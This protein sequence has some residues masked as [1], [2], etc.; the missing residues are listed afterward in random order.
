MLNDEREFPLTPGQ[1]DIWLAQEI[2][3]SAAEWIL[4]NLVAIDGAAELEVL[5]R[6]I[7]LVVAEAEPLRTVFYEAGG[8]VVQRAADYPDFDVCVHDLRGAS[9]PAAEVRRLAA[10]MGRTPMPLDGP[11]FKFALAS[12]ANDETYIVNC[13]HHIAV[14]GFGAMLISNRLGAVYSALLDDR[15][16]P[17]TYFGTIRDLVEYESDY[18][19]SAD[20]LQDQAYWA[21]HK[22]SE[23]RWDDWQPGAVAGRGE[24]V[25][26]DP[27]QLDPVLVARIRELCKALNVRRSAI[28]AAAFAVL[29]GK[30]SANHS[31]VAVDFSVSRRIGA[32]SM[33]LPAMMTGTVPLTINASPRWNIADLCGDVHAG[34]EC[35]VQH[36]RFPRRLIDGGGNSGDS[37]G[38]A[39]KLMINFIPS[40]TTHPY[41]KAAA[42]ATCVAFGGVTGFGVYFQN[43]GQRLL[44]STQGLAPPFPEFATTHTLAARLE[45]ILTAMVADPGLRLSSLDMLD[46]G[47]RAHLDQIGN[48]AALIR[49]LSGALLSIPQAFAGQVARIPDNVALVC[50]GASWT[51]REVDE[52]AHGLAHF[53]I[54]HGAGPGGCV[55]LVF[56]RCAEA[57]IA[58]LGV[59]KTGAAYV[60]ID[61]GLPSARVGFM[62]ADTSPVA[63]LTTTALAGRLHGLDVP[64]IEITD[65]RIAT[66]PEQ[67]L[68][69]PDAENLAYVIYTSGT[70]GVPKGVAITHCNVTALMASLDADL[71]APGQ[72]WSQ[73]H[74]YSFDISGWEIFGALLHGGRLVIVPEVVARSP[75]Q[76]HELLVAEQVSVLSQTPSAVGMLSSEGLESTA[77][78]VGGEACPGELVDRWAPGRVMINEYGPT[79]TTMWVALS[80]PLSAES[81]SPPIGMPV[82]GAALFVLDEWL[83]AVPVGAVGELYVAGTGVGVGYWRRPGLTGSR[84]VACPFAVGARMY[85]TGDLVR[86]RADGQLEYLGRSDEQVKVRGYRIELGEI[87]AALAEL[88]GVEQAVVIAR[89][90]RPGDKCLVGYVTGTAEVAKLRAAL[91][92]RLPGY[93]VPS[94]VV[95]ID[96]LPLTVSG[97]LDKRA[98]PAPDYSDT[99]SYRAPTNAVEE[100]LAG[101]FAHVLGVER[102]G[103]DDSFFDL[104]G[105]SLLAMRLTAAVSSGLN[106]DLSVRVVFDAP[107]V[108]QLAPRLGQG[109]GRLEPLVVGERPEVVP[110]S[111]AQSRLWFIDQLQGPSSTDNMAMALRLHGRLGA[112]LLGA[113]LADVVA[114]HE[115][116]RTLFV[117]HGG[118]PR[119]VVI[120]ANEADFGLDEVDATGWPVNRLDEAI[121][122]AARHLFDLTTQIP[123]YARIFRV[124][125]DEHVLVAVAHHIA[126]DG[127]SIAPLIRDLSG[128]Y[129]SRCAGQA[130]GWADLPVQYVDY[131]LWQRAQFGDLSD[132]ES[133]IAAQ[134]AYWEEALA[135]MPEH[136]Q[137]PTDRPYPPVAD[138]RGASVSVEWSTELQQRID[139]VAREHNATSFMVMQ[140]GLAVLLSNLS[141]S[142][143]VAMGFPIGGR[144]DPVLDDLVGFFVN[145]L[146]LRVDLAGDP[147]VAELL[148]QVRAR[149]LAA[150]EYQDVPFEVLVE[151]LNP[152]RS[153]NRHPLI[154]VMLSWRKVQ[155]TG[156]S[157][158]LALGDL[159]VTQMPLDTRT[160]RVD[161][162]FALAERRTRFGEPAGI[163]G[164][165]EFRKDVFDAATIE[166][167]TGRLE[168]LLVAITAEPTQRLSSI[169]LLDAAEHARLDEWGHRAVLRTSAPEPVS[170]PALFF[171]QVTRMPEAVALSF[172]G[173][174]MTYRELDEVSNRLAHL[175]VSHGV[176]PGDVVGLLCER[177]AQAVIAILAV[178][179]ARAAY[180]PI[181]PVLP[182]ARIEFILEDA[183]PTA[184]VSSPELLGRLASHNLTVININGSTIATSYPTHPLP[185]PAADD[186]AY[187]IYTSGTT[188][189]PK[190]VAITHHNV[191]QLM[192]SLDDRLPLAGAWSQWHSYGF[193]VSVQEIF[194]ALLHG[195]RLVIVPE[196]MTRAPEDFHALLVAEQ[197]TVLSQTPS[198]L[199]MLS[200]RGLDS[201]ALLIMG[202][203]PCPAELVDRWAP[204]RAMINVCGPTEVSMFAAMSAPLTPASAG[205]PIGSPVPGAALFVLDRWLRPVPPGV[206][207]ELYVAGRVGV[208]YWRR[209]GLTGSRFVACPFGGFGARMYRTGD[210]VCWRPDGQLD[211]RGRVDQQVK[212]RGYRIEC[213]EVAAALAGVDGVDQAVVIARED[214]PG[215]KRL[216]G[217]ITGT[218]DPV[219]VRASL[220]Q[221]LPGYMV[222]AAVVVLDTVPLTVNGKLDT[223]ALPVPGYAGISGYRAP[224]T[225]TEEILAGTYAQILGVT[226]VGI[227][228]SFF[229]LGGDSLSAMRVIAAINTTLNTDLAVRALFE[230]PMVAQ[231]ASRVGATRSGGRAPLVVAERPAVVALSFAQSRLWFID[232]L[233]GPSPVYNIAVG[234]HLGG[235]LDAGALSVALTD[236]VGRHESLRTIFG[237]AEGV[238]HQVVVAAERA[239]VSWSSVDA[240]GWSHSRLQ[241]AIQTAACYSFD[242]AVEI[243]V[244]ATLYTVADEQHV[245]VLV[246]HHIA[247]DGWSLAPLAADLGVAYASRCAGRVPDWAPLPVQYIDYTLWQRAD[248]GDVSDPDSALAVQVA[249]WEQ[250]LAG[251][252]EWLQLPTDRP[253]PPVADHRGA[254]VEVDWSAGLQQQ[255]AGIAREHTA[256]SF[257]V[258]HAGLA[259]LLSGL[260]G[261]TDV[262]VGVPIAGRG[263]PALDALVGFFVNTLVLRVDLSANPTFVELL[264]QTRTRSLAAYDHQDVPFEVLVE[265]LDPT[266]SQ[267]HHPVFQVMLA[268]QNNTVPVLALGDLQVTALP[269]DTQTARMDLVFSLSEC[270]SDSGEPAGISGVVEFRTDVFDTASIHIMVQRLEQILVAMTSEPTQ[271]V[272]CLDLLTS[273]EHALLD[274]VGNRAVLSAP[275]AGVAASVPALFAAVVAR[276][277]DEVAVT[278]QGLSLTYRQL[279]EASTGLALVLAGQGAGPGQVVALLLSRSVEAI[280]A[281]LAVLKAGA[282]YLP[283]DPHHPDARI[284]FMLSD[285]APVVGGST[286]ALADRLASYDLPV[287]DLNDPTILVDRDGGLSDP[288]PYGLAYLIYTSGTTGVPKGVAIT[289]HNVTQLMRSL[290]DR[291]PL[292]GAWSQWHSYGFDFSVFEIFGALLHGGRLVVVP[293]SVAGSP[294]DFHALLVAEHVSVLTSTPSALSMLSSQGLESVALLVGGEACPVE[295]VDRWAPGRVMFNAYGPTES[296]MYASISTPLVAGLG[297]APIGSPVVGA[298]L[299][300]LDEWLRAVPPGVVGEL[301][302]AGG[303]VGVG[304]WRRAGLTGSRFLACPFGGLGARMYRTGDLVC[305]RPDGQLDY[306]G[307]VDQQ[308]KIRGYRI[309]CRE[310]AAVLAGV[311]GVDQAVVIAREDRP[312]DKRL[313]GYITGTA[314]PVVVRASLAQR[315]PGY[316]VPA[317]VVVLDTVPLTVNG[318]LDTRAL[319]VP[320]YAGISGYRAPCTPTEE[321]LAGI[322]AQILGVT[323]VGIDDSFFDLGGDSLSA[324]RVIA[325]INTTLNT[326]LAVRAL[327]EAPTVGALSTQLNHSDSST[328]IV[329]VQTLKHGSGVPLFAIHMLTGLSWPYRILGDHLDC[330]IIGIQQTAQ[331]ADAEPESIRA[332]AHTYADRLQ[333]KFPTGPYNLIGWSFGGVLAHQIGIELTERG[334]PVQRLILLDAVPLGALH[335]TNTT[336]QETVDDSYILTQVLRFFGID[337]PQHHGLL[338]YQRV[339]ELI[340]RHQALPPQ[341]VQPIIRNTKMNMTYLLEHLPGVFDG[342]VV[343]FSAEKTGNSS[344][345]YELWRPYITGNITLH[346]INTTHHDMLSSTTLTTYNQQLK[347]SL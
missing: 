184:V 144:R 33:V 235:Q 174:F 49:P 156:D 1:L 198:A 343:I 296:T 224:C 282:A 130:P 60:P 248:L 332:M 21:K 149:G 264:A 89:E 111:F 335:R 20:F 175:L 202:G 123:F 15:P 315:L 225:P 182:A 42:T 229:D 251:L 293:E 219:V 216:V 140:A 22:T 280:V 312:G 214:R 106:A 245:L 107:T 223:R 65:P 81:G 301:Y 176:G 116:L 93:M 169:D 279:D 37:S 157:A 186:V 54:G 277:P 319:P 28:I 300:V 77:L 255:I 294:E 323:R 241:E 261:T 249:Y 159:Q 260:S 179:K 5:K 113:A 210:L 230:A 187:L 287:L 193:D 62:L 195:G 259:V 152:T 305:W 243:P 138:Y 129:A 26:P 180:V 345:L 337:V 122:A 213:R 237:S 168:R 217:Y 329:G 158:E 136:L 171:A 164:V 160:A 135:G 286:G 131:T 71:A 285:A 200:S 23:N 119:Q 4:T 257:M 68:A 266:R 73:W 69:F 258:V 268:W 274:R 309:E 57:V 153:L 147:S 121:D 78:L 340:T 2:S 53:L 76:F 109:R 299:F 38:A 118:T 183:A 155:E 146:V 218:A 148:T 256:T 342:D 327:F 14:D 100:I 203:E 80:A 238:P 244:H 117:A 128:A 58:M 320:G 16:V 115:S 10:S 41:G 331:N 46:E 39:S 233:Q 221:R 43:D 72:V 114:R 173:C 326:D 311:D 127:L 56:E 269:I 181:D 222:P 133:S 304:Y 12:T 211:Y 64:V 84:F 66:S 272:S 82:A 271:H 322:Y 48:R 231:L 177:S 346:P 161:L 339:H 263:H 295:V 215:D 313:V 50:Q 212:I 347:H 17:P 74:S 165:V 32:Q 333:E 234:L 55:A 166:A 97:K 192:R 199:G 154:Q 162:S 297:M 308:V 288:D 45:Q 201:V 341:L 281:I 25:F 85:R 314:D 83:R 344:A 112:G 236:V 252:P 126:V 79:E 90:D 96:A 36:Q 70:T 125:D 101:I 13:F 132:S 91:A 310:V 292:A 284:G 209:A 104:G 29:L 44:V 59:L 143:D 273:T 325:A 278:C 18:Q 206:V 250:A 87:Q 142:S 167:L 102:V 197:V 61:P 108:A 94:A 190:G 34:I 185:D 338:T 220:A 120:P 19:Q 92:E 242:L 40:T 30:W 328:E 105:D 189:V 318:K 67:S 145:T 303:G 98:L 336:N 265:R 267:T 196:A 35:A 139:W 191:T 170:I 205:V 63:V 247:A 103:V 207:G 194:G 208:G 291:L 275:N 124:S 172:Q 27:V 283:I 240:T 178:L 188:G 24:R 276:V 317:A 51:Y 226:Q 232:Q 270:F 227:D 6:T 262:A 47:E 141:A 3:G 151:R 239:C 204:G 307:R 228:D 8:R 134:L 7:R 321:I 334:C 86:W 31:E 290:D 88:D 254:T 11:L 163:G 330:P 99:N 150:Y 246:V 52:A 137:L 110:L 9:D 289:H 75:M 324:M 306:R 316:M 302:V 253:Y 95:T 298:A